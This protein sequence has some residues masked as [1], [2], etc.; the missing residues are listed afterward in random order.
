MILKLS[1]TKW[2][3]F[4]LL[5]GIFTSL[6]GGIASLENDKCEISETFRENVLSKCK[7]SST[8]NSCAELDIDETNHAVSCKETASQECRTS[9]IDWAEKFEKSPN[10]KDTD[11]DYFVARDAATT[12]KLD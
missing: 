1:H 10:C 3:Y 5:L 12:C 4:T 9:V 8:D 11:T 7:C 2:N 6:S